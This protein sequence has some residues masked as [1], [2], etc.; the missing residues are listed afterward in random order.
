VLKHA[1]GLVRVVF[2]AVVAALIVKTGWEA[3][4]R[5]PARSNC[6][7]FAALFRAHARRAAD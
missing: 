1:A 4:P 2:I 6:G 5:W 3:F 7:V